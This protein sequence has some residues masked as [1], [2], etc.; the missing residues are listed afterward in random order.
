MPGSCNSGF[1]SRP[2][3]A[4]GSRRSNGFDV[5]NRNDKNP[6]LTSPSMLSTR[7]SVCCGNCLLNIDTASV[8]PASI[9]DHNSNEPSCEPQV[10]ATRYC[11]GSRE[12]EFV[13]TFTTEKSL[14]TKDAARQAKANATQ[15]NCA[16]ASGRPSAISPPSLRAAPSMGMTPSPTATMSER[17]REK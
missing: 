3:A 16:R 10:A 13:A 1:K 8:H 9:S 4:P 11:N 5:H 7:E 15:T 6:M 14:L 2:A 12:L 17:I